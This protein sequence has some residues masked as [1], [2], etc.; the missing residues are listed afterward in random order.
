MSRRKEVMKIINLKTTGGAG[1]AL[2]I[3][4]MLFLVPAFAQTETV[5]FVDAPSYYKDAKCVV[6]HGQKAEKKFDVAVSE[7]DMLKVVL[8][9][10]KAEKPPN[11][12]GYEA[13]GLNAE[14]AKAMIAYMKSIKP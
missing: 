9:G 13:K 5:K 4:A 3:F 8:A 10:K 1:S 12:P 6:C 7:E 11:M 14:Q 2:I